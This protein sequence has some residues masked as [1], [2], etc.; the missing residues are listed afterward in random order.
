[1]NE[2]DDPSEEGRG[3]GVVCFLYKDGSV[4]PRYP[5]I[6]RIDY[7]ARS[8]PHSDRAF[9]YIRTLAKRHPRTKFV[10]IVG[11]KCIPDL[12][13][14]RLPMLLV[15]RKG[16]IRQQ[17]V[18][19]GAD[20]ERRIEGT[21]RLPASRSPSFPNPYQHYHCR[22]GARAHPMRGDHPARPCSPPRPRPEACRR[23]LGC[24]RLGRGAGCPGGD[25]RA[26]TAEY[27][28]G[29]ARGEEE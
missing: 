5:P 11:D 10:S 4:L 17:L 18:A 15:Y 27:P 16:E 25:E 8:I 7:L 21:P 23:R 14:A 6:S 13:D 20:R 28:P 3:T 22:T 2:E 19:W 1:V 9:N 26:G 29:R 12:P 24:R